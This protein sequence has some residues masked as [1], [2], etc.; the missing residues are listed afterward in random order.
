MPIDKSKEKAI[1]NE[2]A[3]IKKDIKKYRKEFEENNLEEDLDYEA[4]YKDALE[5]VM[6]TLGIKYKQL[7]E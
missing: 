2:Y 5:F 1:K 3:S 4:G 7:D 6:D